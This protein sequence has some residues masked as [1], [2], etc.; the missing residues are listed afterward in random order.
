MG[1]RDVMYQ[2]LGGAFVPPVLNGVPVTQGQI[3]AFMHMAKRRWRMQ[4]IAER[5]APPDEVDSWLDAA[6]RILES[7][8]P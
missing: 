7:K 8:E 4:C 6:V 2:A 5:L 3:D 1:E